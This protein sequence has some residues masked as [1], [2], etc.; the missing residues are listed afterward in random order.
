MPYAIFFILRLQTP[1]V[2]PCSQSEKN[3]R[4]QVCNH[5]GVFA[6]SISCITVDFDSIVVKITGLACFQATR[7]AR[8]MS[9]SEWCDTAFVLAAKDP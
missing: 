8:T 9:G 4:N 3:D 2:F 7:K 5:L 6:L 1:K